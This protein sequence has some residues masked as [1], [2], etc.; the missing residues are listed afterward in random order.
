M[1]LCPMDELQPGMMVAASV[2]HPERPTMELLRAGTEVDARI[3][4]RLCDMGVEEV[5]IDHVG[6]EDLDQRIIGTE[7]N[8]GQRAVY[9]ELKDSLR[10]G[11]RKTVSTAEINRFS[12]AIGGFVSTVIT[13]RSNAGLAARMRSGDEPLFAHSS[14]V[15]YLCLLAGIELEEYI[16]RQRSVASVRHAKDLSALG[17]A[18]MLHDIGK[19][20]LDAAARET[21]EVLLGDEDP[22]EGY[23]EHTIAGYRLLESATMP[24]SAKL[25]VLMHHQRYDGSGWP[26]AAELGRRFT[27]TPQGEKIHIFS[28]ILAAANVLDN[29]LRKVDQ[30][31]KP[32][33]LALA[34][35]RGPMFEGWFDPIV[36]K[37]LLRQ[38]PPFIVGSKVVLSD[39]EECVVVKPNPDDP[40]QPFVR[41]LHRGANAEMIDLSSRPELAIASVRGVDVSKMLYSVD[42]RRFELRAA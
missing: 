6:T 17:L 23:R 13:N 8:E 36:R 20:R 19:V 25:A 24:A 33:I 41:P 12:D 29:L 27:E 42:N 2:T 9:T 31:G 28:R 15:A 5:W 7:L 21:H 26:V 18:G 38:L 4:G 30:M 1:L 10:K 11:T 14:S 35:F 34:A 3:I 16:I 40:C 39:A 37:A 22:P 32:P